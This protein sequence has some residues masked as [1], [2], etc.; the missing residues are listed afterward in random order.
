MEQPAQNQSAP[1][2]IVEDSLSDYESVL[3]AFHKLGM[4]NPVFHCE[5]GEDALDFLAGKQP[6]ANDERAPRPG[7]ILLDLNLPGTDGRDV[8]K[9]VKADADLRSIPVVILTTSDSEKDVRECYLYGA[10]SYMTKSASWD[11]FFKELENF[12]NFFLQT[13]RLP[14]YGEVA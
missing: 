11:Q 9:K 13:A 3:R 10:N 5:S 1:I 6:R 14:I 2:L 12:K 8:L 4:H 7:I